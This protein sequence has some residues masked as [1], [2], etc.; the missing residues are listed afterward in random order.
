MYAESSGKSIIS[1]LLILH[2]SYDWQHRV[3]RMNCQQ[4]Y[5]PIIVE[6]LSMFTASSK[7]SGMFSG[8]E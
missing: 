5:L 3:K 7:V 2:G 8:A 1:F 6:G 4:L